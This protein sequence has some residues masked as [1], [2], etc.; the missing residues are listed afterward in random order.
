MGD[1]VSS[2]VYYGY[3]SFGNRII[4]PVTR[5]DEPQGRLP[6]GQLLVNLT[7]LFRAELAARGEGAEEVEGIR[8]AHLQIFGSIKAGG[9][10]L[11]D[12]A[13]ATDLSLSSTAELVDDLEALG[14]LERRADPSDGR[15]KLVSLTDRGWTA[16]R[17]GRAVI[18]RIETDWAGRI[19]QERFADLLVGL[20]DL[21]DALDPTI[22]RNYKAPRG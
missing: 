14:Y 4:A 1:L 11:T 3:R 19:G 8:P 6:I 21:L 9:T 2:P 18:A 7:R 15:A 10:R 12:L 17:S 5:Q 20:Q 22:T 16:V 13:R